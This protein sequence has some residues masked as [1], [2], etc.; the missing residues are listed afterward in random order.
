VSRPSSI[1]PLLLLLAGLAAA[2]ARAG[3]TAPPAPS[4]AGLRLG[5]TSP[6]LASPQEPDALAEELA[7]DGS[8][9]EEP[10]PRCARDPV[11]DARLLE[12]EDLEDLFEE[13]LVL[14]EDTDLAGQ[15]DCPDALPDEDAV[16]AGLLPEWLRLDPEI[17]GDETP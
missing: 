3:R 12:A 6:P 4:F 10:A 13:T 2:P 17:R 16:E 14:Q 7:R 5:G 9:R 8:L 11:V 1:L 15:A